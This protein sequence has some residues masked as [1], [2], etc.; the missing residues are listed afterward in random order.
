MAEHKNIDGPTAGKA[1]IVGA[2]IVGVGVAALSHDSACAAISAAIIGAVV[3]VTLG[4]LLKALRFS[5]KLR[6]SAIVVATVS[7][8]LV[9]AF[10]SRSLLYREAVVEAFGK[11]ARPQFRSINVRRIY[12]GGPG[13]TVTLMI[14]SAA[15]GVIDRLVQELPAPNIE[16]P[17]EDFR[18]GNQSWEQFWDSAF[19]LADATGW[20]K[21]PTA[22]RLN[23]PNC[24][25][26]FEQGPGMPSVLKVIVWDRA[27]GQAFVLLSNGRVMLVRV[28]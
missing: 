10:V 2:L 1:G 25:R 9:L 5:S 17:I 11:D 8:S 23:E 18:S 27:T 19:R 6:W 20:H 24:Y 7:L 4:F 13:D 26:S 21:W 16:N 3:A 14:I 22:P 12:M 28:R 15:P